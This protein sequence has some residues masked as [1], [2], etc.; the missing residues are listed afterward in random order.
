MNRRTFLRA[1]LVTA[2]T[3]NFSIHLEAHPPSHR[4]ESLSTATGFARRR[5]YVATAFGEIAYIQVGH[6]PAALFLHGFPL[7]S[8]QWRDALELLAPHRRCIAPDFLGMGHTRLPAEADMKPET[9]MRM[10]VAF[11]DKLGIGQSDVIANDSG[12]AVA[13]L[14][15]ARHPQRIRSLLLSNCD[16]EIEC[17]PK[18][19]EPVIELARHRRYARE[20]LVPW[21]QDPKKA[22]SA[23]G[24]GGMCYVHPTNP[25]DEAI[26]TYFLPL[27]ETEERLALTDR[28]AVSLTE[29]SLADTGHLLRNSKVPVGIAWGMADSIFSPK[30]L[31]HLSQSVGNLRQVER[32]DGYK[33]F[34]PEERPDVI[35]DQ[36]L[37]LWEST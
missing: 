31:E 26:A 6:G 1:S 10:L 37:K 19:M 7:N 36:A 34:W 3:A 13:Q 30:G 5:R 9:Q 17:P 28:F 23:N 2:S 16:T 35:R 12:G 4:T 20:W 18:A 33:L 25:T 21:L 24:I 29:N 32:L 15:L 11:L 14:L 27:V 22:R 8:F